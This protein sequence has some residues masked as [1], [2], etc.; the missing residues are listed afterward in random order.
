MGIGTLEPLARLHIFGSPGIDGIMFPDGTLQTTAAVAAA[1][2]GGKDSFWQ[3]ENSN[4]F[5]TNNGNI[6]IGTMTPGSKLEVKGDIKA[7]TINGNDVVRTQSFQIFPVGNITFTTE[8]TS[9]SSLTKY[10]NGG[11]L[12]QF[13]APLEG[14]KRYYRLKV[15]YT[16]NIR[17]SDGVAGSNVRYIEDE[18]NVEIFNF[19]L[20]YSSASGDYI[21]QRISDRFVYDGI[22]VTRME[23]RSGVNGKYLQ[24]YGVWI[25]AEDVIE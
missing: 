23:Y 22:E 20:Q 9:Y 10:L 16:D 12:S 19:V 7:K 21:N 1:T 8:G 5:N 15:T 2:N 17:E 3:A 14:T 6:G 4:V 13:L 11:L 25:I 18:G 24:I